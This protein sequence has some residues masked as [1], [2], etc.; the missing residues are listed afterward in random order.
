MPKDRRSQGRG[1]FLTFVCCALVAILL[2]APTL[3]SV[4]DGVALAKGVDAA[5]RHR[6]AEECF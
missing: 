6:H 2:A 1:L 5:D 3:H 4:A